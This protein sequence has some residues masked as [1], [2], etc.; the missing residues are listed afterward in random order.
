MENKKSP[1][2]TILVAIA[3]IVT[4]CLVI[5]VAISASES[6]SPERVA[7]SFAKEY[8]GSYDV[9]LEIF[10]SSNCEYLQGQFDNAYTTNR[11][12]DP[13]TTHHKRSLGF[14]TASDERMKEI[15]CY[16]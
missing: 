15:G 1:V 8:D 13:G 10:T 11:A 14:M 7:Q 6:N 3:A 9:Y 12:S 4:I 16:E 2:K 5:I